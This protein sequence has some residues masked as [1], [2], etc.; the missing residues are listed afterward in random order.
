MSPFFSIILPTFNRSDFIE[1]AVQSVLGQE[2]KDWELIIVD[3]GSTDNTGEII[4]KYLS[5]PR[6][7]YHYQSN[8]ERSKARNNGIDLATG[9]F[10]CFLDSDDQY[11]PNHLSVLQQMIKENQYKP[12]LYYTNYY[13]RKDGKDKLSKGFS[14]IRNKGIYNILF[15]AL[16]QTNSVCV[17]AELLIHE[18]FPEQFILFEDNHLWLRIIAKSEMIY[19]KTPTNVF[20]NH[21]NRS[22]NISSDKLK[23]KGGKYI[24]VLND[25][26]FFGKY[27]ELDNVI[28]EK[29][30]KMFMA[31]K[32][33]VMSFEAL[34]QGALAMVYY[35]LFRAMSYGFQLSNIVKYCKLFFGAPFFILF[36]G[37]F[38]KS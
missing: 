2:I 35:F 23:Q 12:A 36:S 21:E 18:R 3:D 5:D 1:T 19:S 14:A 38:R 6:I 8:Q 26:F 7:K 32:M 17:S 37:V 25:L 22:L 11:L 10:I 30:K 34:N 33:I 29:E 16:L 27:Q 4:K 13:V 28:S 20:C 15:E 31:S 9:K 24:E